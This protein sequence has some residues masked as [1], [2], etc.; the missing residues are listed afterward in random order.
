MLPT[1]DW[2]Q[3][4]VYRAGLEFNHP[5][6]ARKVAPHPGQWPSRWGLLEISAP[7]AVLM[8]LR[9]AADGSTVL[10]VYEAAGQATPGV[11]VKM[12]NKIATAAEANLLEDA[13]RKLKVQNDRIQFDLHPFEIKTIKFQLKAANRN[14]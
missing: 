9:P 1:G 3:A 7:N 8:A 2:R 14:S 10:R 11:T 4:A 12:N 13:G 5:L 6:L